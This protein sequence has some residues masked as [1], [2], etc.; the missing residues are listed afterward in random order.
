MGCQDKQVQRMHAARA[1]S[2]QAAQ[3]FGSD[4]AQRTAHN[5]VADEQEGRP[6]R[7]VEEDDERAGGQGGVGRAEPAAHSAAR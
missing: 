5:V 3:R 2:S 1:K 6:E 7:Q 4:L